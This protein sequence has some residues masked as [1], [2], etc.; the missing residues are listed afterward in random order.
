MAAWSSGGLRRLLPRAL[1]LALSLLLLLQLLVILI[2]PR[3]SSGLAEQPVFTVIS[4]K[5]AGESPHSAAAVSTAGRVVR[6]LESGPAALWAE[7]ESAG[8]GAYEEENELNSHQVTDRELVLQPWASGQ[9]SFSAE[10]ERLTQFITTPQVNCSRWLGSD[11]SR[12][13]GEGSE[14]LCIH[15][16]MKANACVA[17]SFSLDG[18]DTVFL[19]STLSTGCEVHRFDPSRRPRQPS[20]SGLGS[21]Q[22]HQ[23]WLDWRHPRGRSH[24]GGLGAMPRRLMDIMDSLGHRTVDVLRADL[25]SAEWRVLESWVKDGTLRK[26]NQ[27]IVTIHLQWAGFEVGGA[28]V[29]VVRFWYSVLSALHNSGFRLTHSSYGRGHTVLRHELP[30]THSSYTLSWVRMN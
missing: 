9:P 16:W 22:H 2:V 4:I 11:G 28:E 14:T 30:D 6:G 12:P 23:A 25:E 21:I 29:E 10:V 19:D 5:G 7:D 13:V 27:L 20:G 24:R 1:M 26:I 3:T 15:D 8:V 18:K 17:Y